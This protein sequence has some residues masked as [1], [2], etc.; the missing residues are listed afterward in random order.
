[1]T[2]Y[3]SSFVKPLL[4][5]RVLGQCSYQSLARIL[6]HISERH[7]E[8]G[9]AIFSSGQVAEYLFVIRSGQVRLQREGSNPVTIAN[10][11]CGEESAID[12]P[13]HLSDAVAL[14]DV[15]VLV[16]PRKSA[17]EL[18]AA[19]PSLRSL[20]YQS[21]ALP[22]LPLAEPQRGKTGVSQSRAGWAKPI[23]WLT[24][25]LLP[26]LTIWLGPGSGLQQNAVLFLAVFVAT[27]CMWIFNLV[28]EY[29]PGIFAI[30]AILILGVAPP[31]AVLSGFASDGF[32][33]AMSILGLGTVI[34]ASGLSYRFL[35][36]MLLKLPQGER[37]D[38]LGLLLTGFLLTPMVPS[39]NGRVAL[40]AP[41]TVDIV[42]I[43]HCKPRGKLATGLAITTFTG[44]SLLSAVFLSSKSVNFV[45]YGLLPTQSQE[46][47]QWLFWLFASAATGAILILAYVAMFAG[48]QRHDEV[49]ALDK[50]QVAAQLKLLGPLR[51]REWSALIGM[52][53][54]MLAVVTSS[55]HRIQPPWV[56]VA[57]LYVLL[58]YGFLDKKEFKEK[59]DWP[60]LVYL[61][62][63]VGLVG[64]FNA[65]GFDDWLAVHLAW[66]GSFM[67]TDFPMFIAL[68]TLVIF[69]IRLAV[70]I[71]TTI[72]IT[73]AVFMPLAAAS[74]INSWII[75][76]I[77]LVLG[78]MWFFPY[79]CSYYLQ[80][81]DSLSK[82]GVYDEKAFLRFNVLMN[83]A[84]VAAIYASLPYWKLMGL[85]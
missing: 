46:Q 23:G 77:I 72:V 7:I 41:L 75:G 20:C 74:G 28:D 48:I 27:V 80:F 62:G 19:N 4:A 83:T 56:A 34:V 85:L 70:P 49:H 65:V 57:I 71:S 14:E 52:A 73:A 33:L 47:F 53:V 17:R 29:I 51:N 30:F 60:F 25:I 31:S 50:D 76:F 21:L 66:L 64:A 61:A 40:L 12:L 24:T 2:H 44:A 84:K 43:L 6:P 16:I 54:F 9:G 22:G 37:W 82:F 11:L 1:M 15:S 45:I 32:F 39:I 13:A 5:N 79:Q 8:A 81:R 63:I 38:N 55:L 3:E 26:A 36:W 68:L 42:E 67:R 69:A 59:I 78:E 35:L 58:V 18:V 10:G